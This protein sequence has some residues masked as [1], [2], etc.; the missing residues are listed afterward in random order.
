VDSEIETTREKS[1]PVK[2]QI[3]VKAS[4]IACLSDPKFV[5]SQD[6]VLELHN[7]L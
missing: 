2:E 3:N 1:H 4:V 5:S 7:E 6:K